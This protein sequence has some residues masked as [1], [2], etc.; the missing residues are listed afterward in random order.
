[1]QIAWNVERGYRWNNDPL[2]V[3]LDAKL[4]FASCICAIGAKYHRDCRSRLFQVQS[5]MI[6]LLVPMDL[7]TFVIGTSLPVTIKKSFTLFGVQKHIE[8]NSNNE[9]VYSIGHLS[10]KLSERYGA[11]G[12]KVQGTINTTC[13]A[14]TKFASERR[15]QQRSNWNHFR[16]FCWSS[17][18][19]CQR[20]CEMISRVNWRRA[21]TDSIQIQTN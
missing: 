5:T 7:T 11:G 13:R 3:D 8:D 20:I 1:M 16:Q 4:S 14:S 21:L 19:N 15:G 10:R 6:T 17:S 12:S 18:K 2:A 9:G